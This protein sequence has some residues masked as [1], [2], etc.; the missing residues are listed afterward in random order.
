MSK[1]FPV[2]FCSFYDSAP[3]VAALGRKNFEEAFKSNGER[4]FKISF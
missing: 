2:W 1:I 3:E 4:V